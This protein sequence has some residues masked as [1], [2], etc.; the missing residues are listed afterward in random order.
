MCLSPTYPMLRD[1]SYRTFRAIAEQTGQWRKDSLKRTEFIATVGT[2]LRGP[3]AEVLFRSGDDPDRLRGPNL[4]G[5]WMDEASL[6]KREA[7]EQALAR[8]RESG[9]AGWLSATF[10][11]KG[12]Y[13]WTYE[14]FGRGG[15]DVALVHARTMD[16]PFLAAEFIATLEGQYG[17]MRALQELEGQFIDIE[18]AEWPGEYFGPDIWFDDWP[19]DLNLRVIAL[20][21]SKGKNAKHGDYSA[22][23]L[24]GRCNEGKL[25]IEADLARRPTSQIVAQ[26]IEHHRVFKA[27]GF[28]VETNQFQELL[29]D[30]FAE[31]S[32]A[33]G[34]MLPI[35]GID[36][37][38]NKEV[39]I[40]RLGPYLA[41][42]NLRF[43][44]GSRGTELLVQQ[45]R[46]FPEGE[47]DDGPDALE[48]A[49]RLA[50][51]L[52][53]SQAD[54]GDEVTVLRA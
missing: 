40:R 25:W 48:M 28:A 17:S 5:V 38:V 20:D 2:W 49:I 23:V 15:A 36:N 16:N 52:L 32:V 8:L 29:A 7:Y 33:T 4:S 9:E 46:E 1:A 47:H 27:D 19:K 45:L 21:P 43:K 10:T 44:A 6:L 14:V 31:Q 18:G 34:I 50:A 37:R 53:G 51:E 22:F 35:F 11:P 39:R 54:D 41:R 13:H 12:R 42:H 3:P 24:L 26:G 30:D